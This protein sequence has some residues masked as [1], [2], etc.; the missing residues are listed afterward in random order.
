MTERESV[1]LIFSRYP[2]LGKV[3]TRLQPRLPAE[4]CLELHT[5]FLLDTLERTAGLSPEQHLYLSDCSPREAA[6]LAGRHCLSPDLTLHP[7]RGESLG[8]RMWNAYT[9]VSAR[10]VLFLGTDS[11]SLPL[12]YIREALGRL[13]NLPVVVGPCED[14]GYYLLGLSEARPQLFQD[15]SWGSSSVLEETISRLKRNER[16]LL[17]YWYDV[18]TPSDLVRLKEDLGR[19]FEGF[20]GR[21]LQWLQKFCR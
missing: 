11:P 4:A 13:S 1:L 20:P 21:T 18:D 16:A 9:E 12:D 14:G 3:K 15:I 5:A 2:Q 8:E 7:Q 17:P 6:E 19:P 10:R